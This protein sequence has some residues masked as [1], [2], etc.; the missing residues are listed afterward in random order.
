[1]SPFGLTEEGLKDYRGFPLEQALFRLEIEN[2]DFSYSLCKWAASIYE[3]NLTNSKFVGM[4]F[5]GRILS[6]VFENCNFNNLSLING[7]FNTPK[8]GLSFINCTFVNTDFSYSSSKEVNFARC[9]FENAKMKWTIFSNC[10]F[11]ECNFKKTKFNNTSFKGSKFI[12]TKPSD[13]QLRKTITK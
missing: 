13:K 6:R 7:G 8:S 9:S 5:S 10:T 12:S 11:T 4:D 3:C 2:T 1:M